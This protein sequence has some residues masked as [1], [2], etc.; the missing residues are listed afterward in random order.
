MP[1]SN[2]FFV[3]AAVF[4]AAGALRVKVII[5]GNDIEWISA[6]LCMVTIGLW[7]A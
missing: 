2:I 3:L 4:F 5:F 1:V 6:G 7:L